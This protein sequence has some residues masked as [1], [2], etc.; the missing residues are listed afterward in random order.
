VFFLSCDSSSLNSTNKHEQHSMAE[1]AEE[2]EKIQ[3]TLVKRK[4]CSSGEPRIDSSGSKSFF[5]ERAMAWETVETL[6]ADPAPGRVLCFE[7]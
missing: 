1:E 3:C 4:R 5:S 7:C 2:A 6:S